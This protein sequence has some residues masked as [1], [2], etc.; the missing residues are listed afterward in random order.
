M[1]KAKKQPAPAETKKSK[2]EEGPFIN[3]GTPI[4]DRIVVLEAPADE[5]SAGGII[6]PDTAKEKPERGLV[7]A[8]GPGRFDE[9]MTIKI[10]DAILYGKYAG[11]EVKL[12]GRDY[13]IMRES[14][15]LIVLPKDAD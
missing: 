8:I 5:Y 3:V 4:A 6:I 15:V 13:L 7:I 14:D 12:K 9:P 11:T 10:G 1:P 2:I